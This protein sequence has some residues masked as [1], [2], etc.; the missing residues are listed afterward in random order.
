MADPI[1]YEDHSA[2]PD[3]ERLS[4]R[5]HEKE[6]EQIIADDV[7]AIEFAYAASVDAA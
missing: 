3:E 2:S 1:S 5:E 7:S 6:F 4:K